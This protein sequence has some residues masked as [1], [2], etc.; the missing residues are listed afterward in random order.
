MPWSCVIQIP[1]MI[2]FHTIFILRMACLVKEA[3]CEASSLESISKEKINHSAAD[4]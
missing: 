4:M 2:T 3:G 1:H